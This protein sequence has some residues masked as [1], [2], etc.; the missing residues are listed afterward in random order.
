MSEQAQKL[1]L[2]IG[3]VELELLRRPVSVQP[4][5]GTIAL[6]DFGTE[7]RISAHR[8][9]YFKDGVWRSSSGRPLKEQPTYWTEMCRP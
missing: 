2:T 7:T 3:K 4:S 6:M 5:D 9:G 1:V 8:A